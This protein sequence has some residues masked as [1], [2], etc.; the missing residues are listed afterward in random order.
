MQRSSPSASHIGTMSVQHHA[1][2]P[3]WMEI[4]TEDWPL[5]IIRVHIQHMTW[6]IR[7]GEVHRAYMGVKQLAH[8][9][10]F[11]SD[12]QG[13]IPNLPPMTDEDMIISQRLLKHLINLP[14]GPITVIVVITD[15]EASKDFNFNMHRPST[16]LLSELVRDCVS[17]MRRCT[18]VLR[19]VCEQSTN[20]AL[21]H[22]LKLARVGND[23]T[24]HDT[25]KS[26][27]ESIEEPGNEAAHGSDN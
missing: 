15:N 22:V 6:E 9:G 4:D 20:R 13:R 24:V 21:R 23:L 11:G 19:V 18:D 3:A 17:C 8:V 26:A 7:T 16:L 14:C 12:G 10:S 27:C 1:P 2:L 5:V 25:F